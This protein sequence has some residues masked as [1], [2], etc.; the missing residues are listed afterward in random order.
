MVAL[1]LVSGCL[2]SSVTENSRWPLDYKAE[3]QS[4]ATPSYGA[5]RVSQVSVRTPYDNE[6]LAVLRADGTVAFDAYNAYAAAPAPL[7]RGVAFDAL[8]ASG[9]FASVVNGGSAVA[10]A[11]S[12]ELLVTRLALDCREENRRTACAEIVL[13]LVDVRG[14][15]MKVLA[16]SGEADAADGNYGRAFSR[17][18]SQALERALAGAR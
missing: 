9:L 14:D 16:A 4:A 17:A 15:L 13:R 11:V 5:A 6:D 18:V 12:V 1:P 8:T 3:S 2:S 10:T 7:L